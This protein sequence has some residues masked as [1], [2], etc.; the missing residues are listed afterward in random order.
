LVI[1]IFASVR[2]RVSSKIKMLRLN[3]ELEDRVILSNDIYILTE[4]KGTEFV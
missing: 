3:D 4:Q 1:A 2:N